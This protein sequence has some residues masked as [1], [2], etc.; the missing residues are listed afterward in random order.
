MT[1]AS[2]Q[3]NE[4]TTHTIANLYIKQGYI[5]KALDIYRAILVLDPGN[6]VARKK[7]EALQSGGGAPQDEAGTAV[8]TDAPRGVSGGIEAQISELEG[9]LNTIRRMKRGV[10]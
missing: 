10:M 5:E 3:K 8:T 1:G 4:I 6:E 9:W 7:L 2:E